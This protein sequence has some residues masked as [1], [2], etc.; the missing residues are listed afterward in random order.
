MHPANSVTEPHP[1]F[2]SGEWE[3][4]Y[5]YGIGPGTRKEAMHF[6]LTFAKGLVTGAGSDPISGFSWQGTYDTQRMTCHMVKTYPTH[7]INY[8]G[9]V[10]ENGIWGSWHQAGFPRHRGGFHIW[11]KKQAADTEEVVQEEALATTKVS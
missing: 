10:D 7:T 3:G 4:F 6:V 9:N 8:E 5:T 1:A 11:P 2:P